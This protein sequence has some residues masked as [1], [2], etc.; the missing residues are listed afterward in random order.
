MCLKSLK[1]AA[2]DYGGKSSYAA[3]PIVCEFPLQS[4][5]RFAASNRQLCRDDDRY[6]RG[7]GYG[8][9]QAIGCVGSSRPAVVCLRTMTMAVLGPWLPEAILFVNMKGG[10]ILRSGTTQIIRTFNICPAN[11][12]SVSSCKDLEDAHTH[13]DMHTSHDRV[14][15]VT[16][17][18]Q[19]EMV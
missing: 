15:D 6:G 9:D 16:Q 3:R 19:A 14:I 7:G 13:T 4:C 8:K 2:E 1:V 10:Y 18:P 17:S 5:L 12:A 11:L